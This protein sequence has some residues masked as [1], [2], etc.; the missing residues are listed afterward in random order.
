MDLGEQL[1]SARGSQSAGISEYHRK[2][3]NLDVNEVDS[4]FIFDIHSR[5]WGN[6]FFEM[7]PAFSLSSFG[8]LE[9][10]ENYLQHHHD[11]IVS[12][13]LYCKIAGISL[14]EIDFE[15]IVLKLKPEFNTAEWIDG[16]FNH[17]F[18]NLINKEYS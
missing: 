13:P 15:T 10:K 17:G 4:R 9:M 11:A 5:K 6:K 14:N 3:L 16:V 18:Y 12:L 8:G 2:N 1:Y 7:R